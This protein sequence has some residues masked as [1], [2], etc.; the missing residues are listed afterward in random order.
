MLTQ[1]G[2][3]LFA[4]LICCCITGF[5]SAQRFSIT[6]TLTEAETGELLP[7]VQVLVLNTGIGNISDQNGNYALQ[8]PQGN[9]VVEFVFLGYKK[10]QKTIEVN[11]NLKL[12]VMM[13]IDIQQIDAVE[14]VTSR[15]KI[16]LKSP[17]M[18]L[19]RLDMETVKQIPVVLGEADVLRSLILMPGI[20][21]TGESSGGFNVRGGA[22]DQNLVLLDNA[23]LFTS[24][25]LFGLF[26]IYNPDALDRLEL[27]KGSQP[28]RYG[29]RIASV[30]D[31]QQIDADKQNWKFNGGIGFVSSRFTAQGPIKKDT[32]ALLIGGRSSYVHLFL[33]LFGIDNEAYFYDVNTRYSHRLNENT[34][35]SITGYF[36]RDVFAINDLFSNRFGNSILSSTWNIKHND[37]FSSNLSF[38]ISDYV[39]ELDLSFAEFEFESGVSNAFIKYALQ[40][41]INP[42][43]RLQYGGQWDYFQFRTGELKPTTEDSGFIPTQLTNKYAVEHAGFAEMEWDI[44]EKVSLT[45]GLRVSNFLRLGQSKYFIYPDN[46]PLVFNQQIQVYQRVDPIDTLNVSR[47]KTI[48][49]FWNLEPRFALST[50]LTDDSSI[51]A[52]YS[53]NAQ[54]IH[55]LSNTI[56]PTPFDIYAPSGS[57]IKPQ[58]GNQWAVGYFLNKNAYTFAVEAYLKR[59]DNRIDYVDGADLIGNDNIEQIILNGE[60]RSAGLEFMIRK[61]S[62]RLKGWVSYTLSRSEQRALGRNVDEPGI[63][64]GNWYYSPWDKTHDISVSAMYDLSDRWQLSSNFVYQTGRPWTFP[65]GQFVFNEISVPRFEGRN[66]NRLTDF[67]RLDVAF[68]FN[69]IPKSDRYK[70]QW[71]FSIYNLYNRR[72]ANSFNFERDDISGRNE[73]TRLAI[74][75]AVPSV[76]YNFKF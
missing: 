52:S 25:H 8:L 70:S 21:N 22:A 57:F 35:F 38:G 39:Y 48:K 34:D 44:S 43:L 46:N 9:Y 71:V 41:R 63:N 23:P 74:F 76:T 31:V 69:P 67:H 17:Q 66:L 2:F 10:V 53:R 55:L 65:S 36:G 4:F 72:N 14:I 73:V 62:G 30:L 60:A 27:Y 19:T 75:G 29:G 20:T 11:R 58:I 64:N 5:L 50:Q 32:S 1:S 7:G 18:G 24:T 40:H 12:D 42:K 56:A 47:S 3:K 33:P 37:S 54:Y 51:K 16:N 15:E 28:A 45:A 61:I 6:G 13:N 49:T 59:V 26:S 68:I